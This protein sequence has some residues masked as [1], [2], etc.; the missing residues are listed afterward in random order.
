MPET[1]HLDALGAHARYDVIRNFTPIFFLSSLRI[2]YVKMVIS[3]RREGGG[4][5]ISLVVTGPSKFYISNHLYISNMEKKTA[6]L[7]ELYLEEGD[8]LQIEA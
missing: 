6:S 2:F 7:G 4:I 3:G 1:P 8:N 5:C